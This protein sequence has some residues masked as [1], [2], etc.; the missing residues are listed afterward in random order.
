MDYS[1]D[2]SQFLEIIYKEMYNLL[3]S[4]NIELVK[5]IINIARVLESSNEI[6]S[7]ESMYVRAEYIKSLKKY[8][9]LE[10]DIFSIF[11]SY[12]TTPPSDMFITNSSVIDLKQYFLPKTITDWSYD[13]WLTSVTKYLL[14][15]FQLDF[16][17]RIVEMSVSFI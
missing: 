11:R 3:M 16:L 9:L 12:S 13:R 5:E 17:H 6:E 7:V 1:S 2:I 14:T 10:N 8:F 4:P 15:I